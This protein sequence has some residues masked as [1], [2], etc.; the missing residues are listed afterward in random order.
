[1]KYELQFLYQLQICND[2]C[3]LT[4]YGLNFIANLDFLLFFN[5]LLT[6]YLI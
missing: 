4:T 6:I 3:N 5:Y 1:M 2:L